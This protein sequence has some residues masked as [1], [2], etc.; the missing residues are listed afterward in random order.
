MLASNA[1]RDTGRGALCNL[2]G[3]RKTPDSVA[4]RI[5][6]GS[7]R[8]EGDRQLNSWGS[9]YTQLMSVCA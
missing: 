5:R 3:V 6:N 9:P 4:L 1:G 7:S 2:V 8:P